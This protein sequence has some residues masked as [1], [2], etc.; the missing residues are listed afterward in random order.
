MDLYEGIHRRKSIQKFSVM[1][2]DQQ[3]VEK[4]KN[5]ATSLPKLK[6]SDKIEL[7]FITDGTE[8]TEKLSTMGRITAPH[9]VLVTGNRNESCLLSAGYMTEYLVLYLTSLGIGTSYMGSVMDR[10][11]ATQLIGSGV[12]SDVFATVAF[13]PSRN[14]HEVYRNGEAIKRAPL[15][16]LILNGYPTPDQR[17]ILEAV[18]LAPSFMNGQNWRFELDDDLILLYQENIPRFGNKFFA[19]NGYFDM[20]IA[21]AHIEIAATHLG[22]ECEMYH[23]QETTGHP[24]YIQTIKLIRNNKENQL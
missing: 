1:T 16:S 2:L 11:T 20:G 8:I 22:Y 19:E 9:Y 4:I 6:C 5:Q 10:L 15:D 23:D 18:R 14:A 17:T 24:E 7:H 21:L 13:G 12:E 3:V